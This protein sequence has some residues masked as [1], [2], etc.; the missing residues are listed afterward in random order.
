VSWH[1]SLIAVTLLLPVAIALSVWAVL[2]RHRSFTDW[3]RAS[4]MEGLPLWL[5]RIR[6]RRR[7]RPWET[8]GFLRVDNPEGKR[9]EAALELLSGGQPIV[10]RGMQLSLTG[11]RRLLVATVAGRRPENVTEEKA[12]Q[13]IREAE[14]DLN[15]LKRLSPAFLALVKRRRTDFQVIDYPGW[16]RWTCA[17]LICEM[18]RG[19]LRWAVGLR[20]ET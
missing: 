8:P 14:E 9:F 18:H 4:R 11:R 16:E 12:R 10:Y 6:F 5:E 1:S 2:R 20:R 13:L 15:E 17:T 3:L 19:R 7:G